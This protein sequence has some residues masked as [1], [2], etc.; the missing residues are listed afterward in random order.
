MQTDKPVQKLFMV[1]LGCT[2]PGRHTEQHDIFFGIGTTL[3][4]L[5]PA[6]KASWPE[7]KDKIHVDAWREV[8]NANG[9]AITVQEANAPGLSKSAQLFFINLGGYRENEFDEFHYRTVVAAANLDMAKA[10]AKKTAFFK[11]HNLRHAP[12]HPNAAAH[13]DDKYGVDID[14]VYNVEDILPEAMKKRFRIQV[15]EPASLPEDVLH[16]GYFKLSDL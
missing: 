1:L 5:I 14:D 8:T 11:H 12:N 2:P 9:Y 4:D 3:R 7:A 13:I 6:I 16:L 15:S 10:T